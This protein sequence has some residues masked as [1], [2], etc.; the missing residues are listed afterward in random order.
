MAQ[1]KTITETTNMYIYRSVLEIHDYKVQTV[2][3]NVTP[4]INSL[5]QCRLVGQVT[6]LTFDLENLL[7][8]AHS[9]D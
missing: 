7:G 2:S 1:I 5:R 4:S 9:C 3:R 6:T 8:S